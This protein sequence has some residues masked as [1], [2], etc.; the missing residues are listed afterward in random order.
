[1]KALSSLALGT[2]AMLSPASPAATEDWVRYGES[3][4]GVHYFDPSTLRSDGDRRRIW[5]LIDRRDK[6]GNGIHSGKALI[7]IDC[8]AST[9]RYIQT[10]QYSGRMGHGRYLG[11]DGEQPAEN[12]APGTMVDHLSKLVC[13]T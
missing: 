13:R 5:R 11:G 4:V 1:M 9:Y 8:R 2:L 6:V 7:E 3:E 12:I 10:L